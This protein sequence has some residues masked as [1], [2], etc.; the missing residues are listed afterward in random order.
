[1]FHLNMLRQF[2]LL[3][4]LKVAFGTTEHF[5]RVAQFVPA[6]VPRKL[7]LCITSVAF[8]LFFGVCKLV[9]LQLAWKFKFFIT[10]WKVTLEKSTR[11]NVGVVPLH[12]LV[13]LKVT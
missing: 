6:Q 10:P 11:V 13:S 2:P 4:G 7:E 12:F 5:T 8:M 1:M 3:I 9:L